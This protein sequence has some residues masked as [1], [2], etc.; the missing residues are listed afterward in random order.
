QRG[1]LRTVLEIVC[2]PFY[3]VTFFHTFVGDYLTSV[4]KVSQDLCWSVCFFATKEFLE[5]DDVSATSSNPRV[6][7]PRV[8]GSLS[9]AMAL[10]VNG[11]PPPVVNCQNNVYYV[12]IVV[13]LICALPLWWRFLQSLRRIYDTGTWWPNLPNA[14]KYALAQVVALF[15]L[16]H[17]FYAGDSDGSGHLQAFQVT[18]VVLFALSSL[19]T[20]VWDV[21]MDW[22]LGHP[23]HKFL[24]DRQM[25]SRTWVYYVAIVADLFLRFAW[26]L[27]LVPPQS[28][29]MLP[30]YLQPFT[31]VAELFRRT[32]W[33][34]FR[35]ENE[36]LRNTQGFRRVDFIPLHY[37][38]G[39]G[40]DLDDDDDKDDEPL[41]GRV[42]VAKIL[43]IALVV[44]ALS[45][46][47]IV[48][49]R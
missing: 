24:S 45:I 17:P 12:N 33:S 3:A 9:A 22:G 48:I 31:M 19:Y 35:L 11:S 34:F 41:A 28:S 26:T 42:F 6:F 2:S 30:L 36:H 1:L 16:F 27:S 20:W 7:D 29:R 43:L 18:W 40:D 46:A 39:V 25:F 10:G 8:R 13:P 4:V 5:K 38:H 44:L 21:T 47:A 23:E 14:F 49:E 32:F 37:D 15:G